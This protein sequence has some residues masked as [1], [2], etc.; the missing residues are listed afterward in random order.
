MVVSLTML[1]RLI[2]L[3]SFLANRRQL[4][5]QSTLQNGSGTDKLY[6]WLAF[7]E[8]VVFRGADYTHEVSD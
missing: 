6:E 3:R 2:D 4:T 5:T 7:Q 8:D 1:E